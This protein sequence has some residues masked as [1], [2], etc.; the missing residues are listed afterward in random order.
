[1]TT[2]LSEPEGNAVGSSAAAEELTFRGVADRP[3]RVAA[4]FGPDEAGAPEFLAVR[5]VRIADGT[6]LRQVRVAETDDEAR[7]G[8]QRLDNEILAGRRL[9][10]VTQPVGYPP[11]LSRLVGDNAS[12]A[13]PYAL[14]E[15]YRGQPLTVASKQLELDEQLQFQA[16]LLRG[17][18]W[19]AAAGLAHRGISPSTVRWDGGAQQVQ[20]IDFSLSTV[21]GAP[22]EVIGTPPWAA[23]EQQPADVGG[24]VSERD[25]IWAAGRLI[26]YVNTQ[27]ELTD[28]R[29]VN[30]RPALNHLLSG[31]FGPPAN[32]PT[33]VE[34]LHR[35]GA[36]SPVPRALNGYSPLEAGRKSFYAL[37]ARKHPGACGPSDPDPCAGPYHGGGPTTRG[38][39]DGWRGPGGATGGL[40]PAQAGRASAQPTPGQAD[41]VRGTDD[42]TRGGRR[43]KLFSVSA[44]LFVSGL[45][46]LPTVIDAL[47]VR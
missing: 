42:R 21:I 4:A 40:T 47:L 14:L 1:M 23:R 24:L 46:V 20:I 25:D 19:L 34:L 26:F 22:R 12:S 16:S 13:Q 32:R 30:D 6:V 15:P 43:W 7:V 9:F 28:I 17:L 18:C 35:L 45:A 10:E 44:L 8:Y 11:E 29:Q 41:Q 5:S 33:A 37:R 31:V 38:G 39:P 36:E 27:E 2:D 3:V